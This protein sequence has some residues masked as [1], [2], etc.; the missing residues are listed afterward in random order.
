MKDPVTDTGTKKS[1]KGLLQ[2]EK[3]GNDYVLHENQSRE[4][5][6]FGELSTIFVDGQITEIPHITTIRN[7]LLSTNI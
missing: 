4:Q 6:L 3:V 7:R 2:V 5:E 1:A